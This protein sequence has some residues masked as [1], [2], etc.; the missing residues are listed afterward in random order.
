MTVKVNVCC[1]MLDGTHRCVLTDVQDQASAGPHLSL[2]THFED[3][4]KGYI[5]CT[6]HLKSDRS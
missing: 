4:P 5:D 6:Q 3:S 2:T 1:E